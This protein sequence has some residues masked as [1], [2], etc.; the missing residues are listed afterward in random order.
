MIRGADASSLVSWVITDLGFGFPRCMRE[1]ESKDVA[2]DEN[3]RRLHGRG[4]IGGGYAFAS[5]AL[6]SDAVDDARLAWDYFS[7]ADLT[8]TDLFWLDLEKSVLGQDD[9]NDWAR[10]WFDEWV[11]I[12]DR[13]PG[14]YMGS[15]YLTNRTGAG[16]RDHGFASLWYARPLYAPD[17]T[18]SGPWPT[19]FTPP[20]PR[21]ASGDLVAWADSAW[22][23]PPQFWQFAFGTTYDGN[24]FNGTL[25]QLKGLNMT[26]T[27]AD[28]TTM[29]K[30]DNVFSGPPSD[31]KVIDGTNTKWTLDSLLKYIADNA[32]YKNAKATDL[33]NLATK[34]DVATLQS[35]LAAI[36]ADV[37]KLQGVLPGQ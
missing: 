7:A 24:L 3:L 36:A 12:A 22:G 19:S 34:D 37:A 6:G 21:N 14:I 23:E 11:R 20:L 35:Q 15:G 4:A 9:T 31:P 17:W 16:L 25:D 5:P 32:I 28:L 8:P 13:V 27:T 18:P 10:R 29:A 33:A 30:T 2:F 1:P 26:F